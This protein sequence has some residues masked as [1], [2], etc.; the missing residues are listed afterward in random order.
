[1]RCAAQSSRSVRGPNVC[2]RRKAAAPW[3][4]GLAEIS[5]CSS[6]NTST[7]IGVRSIWAISRAVATPSSLGMRTSRRTRSGA[8]LQ[9]EFDRLFARTRLTHEPEP[10]RG[11]DDLAGRQSGSEPAR[12]RRISKQ[13]SSQ[14]RWAL[15]EATHSAILQP[16]PLRAFH[17]PIRARRSDQIATV[18]AARNLA[19][20]FWWLLTR[21]ENYAHART[22]AD[23]QEAAQARADRRRQ[24]P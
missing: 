3:A 20:L 11:S 24:A 22:V 21:E 1:V 2:F 7:V 5:G 15:V 4:P 10:R 18:A 13:G 19:G 6:A 14:A 8:V 23:R 9:N 16:D 12:L 17:Q